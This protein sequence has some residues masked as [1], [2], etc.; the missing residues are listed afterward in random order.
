MSSGSVSTSRPS[1][2]GNSVANTICELARHVRER[3]GEHLT[4]PLVHLV[5]DGQQ[6][7]PGGLEVLELGGQELVALLQ[8]GELLQRQRVHPAEQREVLLGRAAPGAPGRPGRTAPAAAGGSPRPA[9]RTR[10]SGAA[11]APRCPGRTR[12][13]GRRR[14]SRGLG[15]PLAPAAR[16]AAALGAGHLVAVHRVGQPFQLAGQPGGSS[17]HLVQRALALGPRRRRGV[18]LRLGGGAARRAITAQRRARRPRARRRPPRRRAPGP[19]GRLGARPGRALGRRGAAQRVGP[20]GDRAGPLLARSA[21]PAGPPSPR[22]GPRCTR[23][24]GRVALV[25]C[26]APPSSGSAR[27]RPAAARRRRARRAPRPGAASARV[28]ALRSRSAS[29]RGRAQRL[30]QPAESLR[31]GGA[32]RVGRAAA[33]RAASTSA[34]RAASSARAPSSAGRIE[35]S[36]CSTGLD[37]CPRLVDRGLHLDQRSAPPPEPADGAGA[38]RAGRRRGSRPTS[39]GSVGHDRPGRGQVVD[40]HHVRQ[41]RGHRGGAARRGLD[42]IGRPARAP[43]GGCRRRCVQRRLA[44][45]RR[46]P[47]SSD[48]PAGRPARSRSQWRAPPRPRSATATASASSPSA[49]ATAARAQARPQQPGQPTRARRRRWSGQQRAGS[50]PVAAMPSDS[51]ST[52]ARQC[53]QLLLGLPLPGRPARRPACGP[54]RARRPRPRTARRGRGRRRPAPPASARAACQL[55]LGVLGPLAPPRPARR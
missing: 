42:Q 19:A 23:L 13:P 2:P 12:R 35:A 51:A 7:A 21:A 22:P 38:R 43:G 32:L 8:R 52:R 3:G 25:A 40:H 39:S 36:S 4:D 45:A 54:A 28:P 34:S 44:G 41:H 10:P 49:A 33:S 1:P 11:P 53:A 18:P 47:T 20:A 24:G 31:R 5:H 16:S 26:P 29:S 15:D 50:R 46:P 14:R 37:G 48:G 30:L 55:V 17:P 27:P 9:S 6:V